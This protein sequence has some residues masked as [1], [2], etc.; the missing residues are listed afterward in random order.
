MLDRK[1]IVT[2]FNDLDILYHHAK[3]GED[4][5]TRAGWCG[6]FF[7]HAPIRHTE[8]NGVHNLNDHCV[9]VYGSILM[10]FSMFLSQG[11]TLL[12]AL[13]SSHFCR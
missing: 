12:E 7:C 9:A 6:V 13:Q 5:T 10:Q 3:F 8:F 4:R 11:I 2:F 1:M